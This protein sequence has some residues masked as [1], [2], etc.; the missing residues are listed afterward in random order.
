[1]YGRKKNVC[2]QKWFIF[3]RFNFH[4]INYKFIE[5]LEISSHSFTNSALQWDIPDP[6]FLE[7]NVTCV[8]IL[9]FRD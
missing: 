8:H 7:K 6:N 5:V 3:F 9:P 1:M 4:M 2:Q